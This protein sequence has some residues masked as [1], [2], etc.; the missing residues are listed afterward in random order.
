MKFLVVF[1]FVCQLISTCCNL[2]I[3]WPEDNQGEAAGDVHWHHLQPWDHEKC[4]WRIFL[5]PTRYTNS[6][7]NMQ[8]SLFISRFM[9]DFYHPPRNVMWQK[10]TTTWLLVLCVSSCHSFVILWFK[11][12]HTALYHVSLFCFLTVG[13]NFA[14]QLTWCFI[15]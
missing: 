1:F 2:W 3:Q 12:I 6:V 7:E 13:F 15:F 11:S 5:S 9:Q 14:L 10:M 4:H 8:C